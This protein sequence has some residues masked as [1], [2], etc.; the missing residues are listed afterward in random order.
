MMSMQNVPPH[1]STTL[2][3]SKGPLKFGTSADAGAART[4][5]QRGFKS[6]APTPDFSSSLTPEAFPMT[7]YP[8]R[9]QRFRVFLPLNVLPSK[10]KELHLP[11]CS[12]LYLVTWYQ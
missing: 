6:G 5:V 2:M 1:L 11:S 3:D 7:R 4:R 9:Q 8:T 10:A 12:R